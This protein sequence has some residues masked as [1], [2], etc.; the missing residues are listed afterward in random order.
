M[1]PKNADMK[2]VREEVF[3]ML[4]A[5]SVRPTNDEHQHMINLW[6]PKCQDNQ[7]K[8]SAVQFLNDVGLRP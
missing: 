5:I 1:G 3:N 4:N 8:V 7:G 6:W 2:L